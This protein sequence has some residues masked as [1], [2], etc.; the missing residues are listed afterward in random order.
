MSNEEI[1]P[2]HQ[3]PLLQT[4]KANLVRNKRGKIHFYPNLQ[5]TLNVVIAPDRSNSG[6]IKYFQ[7]SY[8]LDADKFGSPIDPKPNTP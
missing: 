1:K 8:E 2:E 6:L 3:E 7:P 4:I 5:W